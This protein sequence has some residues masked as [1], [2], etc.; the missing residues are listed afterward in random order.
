MSYSTNNI[1]SPVFS[2]LAQDKSLWHMPALA[3]TSDLPAPIVNEY[4]TLHKLIEAGSVYQTAVKLKDFAE[5]AIRLAVLTSV[6]YLVNSAMNN[7]ASAERAYSSFSDLL[8]KPPSAGTWENKLYELKKKSTTFP[9]FLS[10]ILSAFA[11]LCK[12]LNISPYRNEYIG[13]GAYMTSASTSFINETSVRLNKAARQLALMDELWKDLCVEICGTPQRGWKLAS[14]PEYESGKITLS[15]RNEKIAAENLIIYDKGCYYFFDKFNRDTQ[16]TEYLCFSNG[17]H[18]SKSLPLFADLYR[19]FEGRN[20]RSN[21]ERLDK[22]VI[23]D[24]IAIIYDEISNLAL[25]FTEDETITDWLQNCL[26]HHTK[27]IFILRGASGC[28]KSAYCAAIDPLLSPYDYIS[29]GN[30]E[31]RC[32]YASRCAF[33]AQMGFANFTENIFNLK[34]QNG[35]RRQI[36]SVSKQMTHAGKNCNASD[37][38]AMLHE[39]RNNNEKKGKRHC[40]KLLYVIDGIDLMTSCNPALP[41]LIPNEKML[42]EGVYLLLT[43]RGYIPKNIIASES[44]D[45]TASDV[46][47]VAKA[48]IEKQCN[49]FAHYEDCQLPED[50][51]SNIAMAQTAVSVMLREGTV[52]ATYFDE[53]LIRH[54]LSILFGMYGTILTDKACSILK[55]LFKATA[56]LSLE[57][58]CNEIGEGQITLSVIGILRDLQP[59][60][61]I[62]YSTVGIKYSISPIMNKIL[63]SDFLEG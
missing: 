60:L 30:T 21:N 57:T 51:L 59:V 50:I 15:C 6:E 36:L 12:A 58:L 26:H 11:G 41:N 25:Y 43:T 5:A 14:P 18:L 40:E 38:A 47:R 32:Y 23:S 31:V 53:Q 13:H 61:M 29:L 55:C 19:A 28:G 4:K 39:W 63:P 45:I 54:Y 17:S 46:S 52:T 1:N 37:I 49:S 42:D 10:K 22:N 62:D 3:E 9:P 44:K 33:H 16:E 27:G 56:P 48:M 34:Y 2:G 7:G 20:T 8:I 24:E 35:I